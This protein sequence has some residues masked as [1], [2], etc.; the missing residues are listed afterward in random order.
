V[1]EPSASDVYRSLE[2]RIKRLRRI[3]EA[4]E[5]AVR[6]GALDDREVGLLYEAT[7]LNVTTTFE[8]FQEHL[9]Y[10]AVLDQADIRG[11]SP[12]FRFRHRG[13]AERVVLATERGAFLSWTK[14]RDAIDRAKLFLVGGRPFTRLERR[15]KE[16]GLLRTLF[17]VRNAIAHQ[18]GPART[19]FARL[20]S[21][22]LPPGLRRRPG[23]YLRKVVGRDT[24]HEVFCREILRIALALSARSDA[25]ADR[26]LLPERPYRIGE[27]VTRGRFR[28][29][30]CGTVLRL[31]RKSTLERCATCASSACPSCGRGET[32]EFERA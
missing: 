11:V 32:A 30:T 9:F 26:Y 10:S 7:L 21:P 4:G 29:T 3:R 18:S 25:L 12:L 16:I 8:S 24:Q 20:P 19:E 5:K 17:V 13:E 15:D 2:R 31:D 27:S 23:D 22:G 1:P 14:V 28:C 6:S